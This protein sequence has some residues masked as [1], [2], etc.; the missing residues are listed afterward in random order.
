MAHPGHRMPPPAMVEDDDDVPDPDEDDLD[1]LDD[2]LDDF[3]SMKVEPPRA[4]GGGGGGGPSAAAQA[5]PQQHPQQA[6]AAGAPPG[7]VDL[8]ALLGDDDFAKELAK[9]MASLLGEGDMSAQLKDLLAEMDVDPDTLPGMMGPQPPPPPPPSAP[10]QQASSSAPAS[11]WQPP[12]AAGGEPEANFSNRIN[13]TIRRLQESNRQAT[14]ASSSGADASADDFM[15]AM[16]KQ[17]ADGAAAGGG[18]AGGGG[19]GDE[20]FSK[21]LLGMMEELT[22][23]EILYEPMKELDD[24]FPRWMEENRGK[25]PA[26]DMR[27]YEEQC[28]IVRD[29]VARYD[30]KGYSDANQADREYIVDLMQKMQAAGSPPPDLVGDMSSATD[31]LNFEEGCAPS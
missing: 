8:E 25:V 13:E 5:P 6:S 4:G 22:N 14:E 15:A 29:I 31:M 23:K 28:V 10:Q 24:R 3:G 9:N 17:L 7:D 19:A 12:P 2:M 1:D 30:S 26:D 16:L 27:R 18:G 21:L 20:D 11:A